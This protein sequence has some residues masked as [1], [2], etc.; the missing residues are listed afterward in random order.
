MGHNYVLEELK[1]GWGCFFK[2]NRKLGFV[3]FCSLVFSEIRQV[4]VLSS[5]PQVAKDVSIRLHSQLESVEK[6]RSLLEQENEDMRVRLQDLEVAKQVLQ[7]EVDKV[8]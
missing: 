5:T 3:L 1:V 2:S 4:E 7:Q 6:K 8:G